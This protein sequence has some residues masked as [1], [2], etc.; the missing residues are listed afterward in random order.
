MFNLFKKK[1]T[2]SKSKE[3]VVYTGAGADNS[4]KKSTEPEKD[5]DVGK[6]SNKVQECVT[7]MSGLNT[8]FRC[9]D[10]LEFRHFLLFFRHAIFKVVHLMQT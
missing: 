5:D 8:Q 2:A 9:N 7:E 1:A 10:F 4:S 3:L 6:S